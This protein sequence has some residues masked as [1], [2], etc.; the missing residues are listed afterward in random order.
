MRILLIFI[1]NITECEHNCDGVG[2]V[3]KSNYGIKTGR[4]WKRPEMEENCIIRGDGM[5]IAY[6]YLE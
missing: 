3:C 6:N 1:K 2:A 4:E 5:A